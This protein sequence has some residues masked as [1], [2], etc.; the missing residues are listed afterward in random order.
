M[1]GFGGGLM[2]GALLCGATLAALSLALPQ[3]SGVAAVQ[4]EAQRDVMSPEAVDETAPVVAG[5]ADAITLPD[6]SP[7]DAAE[8]PATVPVSDSPDQAGTAQGP[9]QPV[10]DSFADPNPAPQLAV[11][12]PIGPAADRIPSAPGNLAINPPRPGAGLPLP[13]PRAE[14]LPHRADAPDG[15]PALTGGQPQPGLAAAPTD[16]SMPQMPL[17]DSMDAARRAEASPPPAPAGERDPEP[18]APAEPQPADQIAEVS[19]PTAMEPPVA[20]Q[21]TT[22]ATETVAAHSDQPSRA[23]QP[24]SPNSTVAKTDAARPAASASR[25]TY[26]APDLALPPDLPSLLAPRQTP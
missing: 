3:P 24:A 12:A 20:T 23:P 2:Q 17:S 25:K 11:P 7:A 9:D 1:A 14:A 21:D 6:D 13:A 5:R 8:S 18:A 10:M 16:L 4:P 26:P 22:A 19:A 15:R